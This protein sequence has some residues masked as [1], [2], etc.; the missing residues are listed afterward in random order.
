MPQTP[1]RNPVGPNR[2]PCSSVQ[3]QADKCSPKGETTGGD[4]PAQTALNDVSAECSPRRRSISLATY[5]GGSGGSGPLTAA[6]IV[7]VAS[8][9]VILSPPVAA[10]SAPALPRYGAG[11]ASRTAAP[12]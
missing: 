9:T 11:L 6:G 4:E 10:G 2:C 8:S 7:V 3:R 5:K 1:S 12:P